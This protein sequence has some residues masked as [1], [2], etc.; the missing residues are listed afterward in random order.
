MAQTYRTSP[1]RRWLTVGV[2]IAILAIAVVL[3]LVFTGGDSGGSG[4]GSGGGLYVALAVSADRLR[5]LLGRR[6]GDR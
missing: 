4:G 3:F 1:S 2:V 6:S 5:A